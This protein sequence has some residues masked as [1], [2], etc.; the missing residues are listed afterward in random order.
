MRFYSQSSEE[1]FI[2]KYFGEEVGTFL[3][4]GSN[5]GVTFSNSRALALNGWKGVCVEPDP[6]AFKKLQELYETS[7]SVF[8]YPFAIGTESGIAKFYSSGTH[9]NKG[10]TGLVSTLKESQLSRWRKEQFETID[11]DVL[12]WEE[13]DEMTPFATYDFVTIDTEGYDLEILEQMDF[14]KM[15]V[16]L[17]CTEWNGDRLFKESARE[18]LGGK[19]IYQ[20]PENL[21]FD[22]S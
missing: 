21:L 19:I 10:D 8:C 20:S 18:I 2:L 5:D 14:E 11:V 12:T 17:L 1:K 6:S 3:D 7:N 22:L 9:L 4:I 16:K 13:F 15:G